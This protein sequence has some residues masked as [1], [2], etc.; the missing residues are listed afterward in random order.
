M[1][2]LLGAVYLGWALGANDLANIFGPAVASRAVRYR[3]A[4]WTAAILV[5]LGAISGG[6]EAL[7]SV[8][9]VGAQTPMSA[10][11]VTL[12]AAVAMTVLIL[13]RMPA[14]SSQAVLGAILGVGLARGSSLDTAVV[15]RLVQAW[16]LTPLL[17]TVLTFLMYATLTVVL[18]RRGL[19]GLETYDQLVRMALLGT[20]AAVWLAGGSIAF[21]IVTFGRRMMLV[22]GRRLVRLEPQTALIAMLGQAM[23]V[24]LFAVQGTPV[25]SSQALAGAVL[26]IGLVKGVRTIHSRTLIRVLLGW[27][28]TPLA[29]GLLGWLLAR[30]ILPA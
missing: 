9:K 16:V 6:H 14:S 3:T 13:L 11:V 28:I 4:I 15:L 25:S 18:K 8:A 30:I 26:G 12:C 29:G 5:M 17:A 22:M 23:T 20:T 27:V 19:G 21:G 2:K 1:V 10:L 7:Q 24:H